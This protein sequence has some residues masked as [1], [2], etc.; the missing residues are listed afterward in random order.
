MTHQYR[1]PVVVTV[2]ERG[3][4]A[5]FTWHGQRYHVAQVLARWHLR[6]RWWE[7]SSV[8]IADARTAPAGA[9]NRYYYRVGC[10]EG[11]LCELY[12]DIET[13]AWILDRVLD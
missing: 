5:S 2:S 9:S 8:T 11:M 10:H 12:L 6:D 3:E 13:D 1:Q 7:A 4:P